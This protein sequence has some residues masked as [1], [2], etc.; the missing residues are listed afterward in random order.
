MTANDE[1]TVAALRR[2]AADAPGDP[3]APDAAAVLHRGRVLRARRATGAATTGALVLALAIGVP[4]A[5]ARH[6]TPGP[7]NP[8]Q[9]TSTASPVTPSAAPTDAAPSP[10]TPLGP[11]SI[12]AYGQSTY[13]VGAG[14][15]A[16]LDVPNLYA[17]NVPQ[18]SGA[19][20]VA[21]GIGGLDVTVMADGSHAATVLLDASANHGQSATVPLDWPA[22]EHASD[23]SMS[24]H[25]PIPT[26]I[27]SATDSF[28]YAYLVGTVPS[29]LHDPVVELVSD[30][31]WTLPDGTSTHLA[32]VP[33][34][35]APTPDG[36]LM[37]VITGAGAMALNWLAPGHHVAIAFANSNEPEPFVPG[38]EQDIGAYGCTLIPMPAQYLTGVPAP[39]TSVA[40]GAASLAG[41]TPRGTTWPAVAPA[42][43]EIAPGVLAATAAGATDSSGALH[44]TGWAGAAVS[45]IRDG[46]DSDSL[47]EI[48]A[49]TGTTGTQIVQKG[50]LD[51]G[52]AT[53]VS[54]Q[55][56]NARDGVFVGGTVPP[57]LAGVHVF[58]TTPGG[59][60][61][62]GGGTT[63][64]LEVPTF[65]APP[66]Q[67]NPVPA[68]RPWFLVDF[69]GDA[70]ASVGQLTNGIG[71]TGDV[72]FAASDGTIVD[73][74]CTR[75]PAVTCRAGEQP[76]AASQAVYA[77][78]RQLVAKETGLGK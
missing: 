36:R 61:Q 68:D 64:V 39:F 66:R 44:F 26:F 3:W 71:F 52:R 59:F 42:P 5:L 23:Y 31:P 30:T 60:T 37:Y 2:L 15:A 9:P 40:D 65:L 24:H 72:I 19:Q 67:N 11:V 41:T 4:A 28:Q 73:D 53:V 48:N 6:G 47:I 34:F 58:V 10:T 43:A 25:Y 14:Q 69:T 38:C 1:P 50:F 20:V 45:V 63:P 32:Q 29:W 62:A 27:S 49:T 78:I 33:T 77:S 46:T 12:N 70:S 35:R 51:P 16:V 8:G 56:D 21:H 22:T 55:F 57:G 74:R 13:A 18:A 17:V 7:V 54:S 76:D 75:A